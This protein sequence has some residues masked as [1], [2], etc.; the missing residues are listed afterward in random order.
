MDFRLSTVNVWVMEPFSR[1]GIFRWQMFG[2]L[3]VKKL[4]WGLCPFVDGK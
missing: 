1:W 4:A 2:Q 3:E